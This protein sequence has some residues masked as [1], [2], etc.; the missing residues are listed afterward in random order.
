MKNQ[1]SWEVKPISIKFGPPV[2]KAQRKS[3][4]DKYSQDK[5]LHRIAP[6][7]YISLHEI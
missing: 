2:Q 3:I 7:E 5:K 1:K 6:S 4:I